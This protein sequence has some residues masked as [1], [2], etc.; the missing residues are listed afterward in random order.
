MKILV[1]EHC[2]RVTGHR[3]HYAALVADAFKDPHDVVLSLPSVI[4]GD[5]LVAA[6]SNRSFCTD[7]YPYKKQ[8]KPIV[9]F[10]STL[11]NALRARKYLSQMIKRHQP[12]LVA[13][14]TADGLAVLTGLLNFPFA[15]FRRTKIDMCVMRGPQVYPKQPFKQTVA[16]A[17]WWLVRRGPWQ[18]VMVMDPR[19][20]S[21]I[22]KASQEQV[23]LCPDPVPKQKYFDR[24]EA[25]KLL[26]L[27]VD[28]RIVVSVGPQNMRKGSDL[29]LKGFAAANLNDNDYL[30]M[31]GKIAPA[32][33]SMIESIGLDERLIVRDEF[34]TE[35]EFQMA[36]VASDVVAVPY[37][38]VDRPSGVV[39]R[40]MAWKRPM[41]MTNRGWLKWILD[42]FD[43]GFGTDSKNA[44]KLGETI[45]LALERSP[46]FQTTDIA[47]E[48]I[49]S[50]TEKNF[51]LTWK[52]GLTL[53]R[54]TEI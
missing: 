50:N 28:G 29:L 16:N 48:F 30:V 20:W 7:F 6:L 46:T 54:T 39:C 49:N 3:L 15:A 36:I 33:A 21:R 22:D 43:A 18:R 1:F 37:R 27:P 34:V 38:A 8:P 42:E 4:E 47:T 14:P 17:K 11:V 35:D 2:L 19:E 10:T 40:S 52:Q 9:G 53:D 23:L 44:V 25:R 5:P 12:D 51:Q 24:R 45:E 41:V 32:I 31:I 13:I 26:N